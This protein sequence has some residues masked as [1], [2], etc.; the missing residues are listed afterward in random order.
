MPLFSPLNQGNDRDWDRD[1]LVRESEHGSFTPKVLLITFGR[2][3]VESS[4]SQSVWS[5]CSRCF[6]CTISKPL[7]T[8]TKE[9]Y[10][11]FICACVQYIYQHDVLDVTKGLYKASLCWGLYLDFGFKHP[12]QA[13]LSLH[14]ICYLIDLQFGNGRESL[15]CSHSTIDQY[16]LAWASH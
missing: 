12:I 2:P 9:L 11:H 4:S 14:K 1:T 13:L 10:N 7:R 15:S 5:L 16:I 8:S 3:L 6:L